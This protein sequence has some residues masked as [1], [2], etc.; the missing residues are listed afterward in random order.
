MSVAFL[1]QDELFSIPNRCLPQEGLL[2]EL[3]AL[4]DQ[5]PVL[6]TNCD[7]EE[8]RV[9]YRL[10]VEDV[11]PSTEQFYLFE[12]FGVPPIHSYALAT[13]FENDMRANMYNGDEK[14][15]YPWYGL[16]KLDEELWSTLSCSSPCTENMLF[17]EGVMSKASWQEIQLRL[18][19]LQPF[20]STGNVFIAGG[21]L[22]SILFGL[23]IQDI[24][25]FLYDCTSEEAE[26]KMLALLAHLKKKKLLHKYGYDGK[27]YNDPTPSQNQ[28]NIAVTRTANAITICTQPEVQIILRLYKTPSEVL[29]GFDVDCCSIGYD[30]QDL[31]ITH[32]CW[33]ALENGYNTVNF[34]RLSPSYEYRLA[35]YAAR[36]LK[37]KVPNL[38]LTRV[39]DELLQEDF[40]AHLPNLNDDDSDSD[41]Q[42]ESSESSRDISSEEA[43]PV[44]RSY[45]R[46]ADYVDFLDELQRPFTEKPKKKRNTDPQARFGHLM[47]RQGLDI[48][49]FLDY[50]CRYFGYREFALRALRNLASEHSD[51]N[52]HPHRYKHSGAATS[53]VQ[54]VLH[55]LYKS[56][57][58]NGH[59]HYPHFQAIRVFPRKESSRNKQKLVRFASSKLSDYG[60]DSA[61]DKQRALALYTE[62]ATF[63][64]NKK[65]ETLTVAEKQELCTIVFH[66]YPTDLPVLTKK[67]FPRVVKYGKLRLEV[68]DMKSEFWSYLLFKKKDKPIY[69]VAAA[70][71]MQISSV[72]RAQKVSLLIAP[73]KY[74]K[75][76]LHFPHIVYDI[77]ASVRPWDFDADLTW[78]I[79]NPGEQMT[80]TFHKIVLE[81]NTK[82]YQGRYY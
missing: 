33:F 80:G 5:R 14:Y 62:L 73:F 46:D 27:V 29:H 57:K 2:P 36:G 58:L 18:S 47:K 50:H 78:K 3:I 40:K 42:T 69:N 8:F 70:T 34:D 72:P 55:Y 35:K 67:D 48:L 52:L 24:D 15:L 61:K 7:K 32:R 26:A 63:K 38:D 10:L 82:W 56:A 30:G 12:Y 25:L 23:P 49:L 13:L 11:L 19:K 22:Y 71:Q 51:Y 21:A 66:A 16:K 44:T 54:Y 59:A 31:H 81:D 43:T 9:L 79:T 1:V 4:S 64:K 76:L 17:C 53:T 60:I 6:I 37:L 75:T 68:D 28:E 65:L 20:L 45:T 74:V 41:Y 77:I 39:N